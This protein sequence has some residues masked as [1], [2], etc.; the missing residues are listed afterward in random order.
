MQSYSTPFR[1]DRAS[2]G[3]SILLYVRE[4]VPCKIIK[5]ESDT[6]YDGFF[7]EINL[8]KEKSLLSCS[9]DSHKK[10]IGTHLQIT[11]KTLDKLNTSYDNI[12]LLRYFKC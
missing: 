11:G 4:D 10:N 1:K 3:G 6:Y 8:R 2:K 5:T 12:I 9:Y 7:I